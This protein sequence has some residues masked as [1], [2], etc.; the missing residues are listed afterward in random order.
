MRRVPEF[1]SGILILSN[2]IRFVFDAVASLPRCYEVTILYFDRVC[3][4]LTEGIDMFQESPFSAQRNVVNESQVLC[5]FV[6]TNSS[7]MG[8]YGH[9]ESINMLALF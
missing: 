9:V 7:A 2:C 5:I 6:E 4:D 1:S 8:Y 3:D